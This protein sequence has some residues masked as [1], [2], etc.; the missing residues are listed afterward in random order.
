MARLSR[1]FGLAAL[2]ALQEWTLA[3]NAGLPD[4]L[5]AIQEAALP[6]IIDFEV[7]VRRT[8]PGGRCLADFQAKPKKGGKACFAPLAALF[9]DG[10]LQAIA[11]EIGNLIIAL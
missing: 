9:E 2:A 7:L 10:L 4:T 8:G 3:G 11:L 1:V 6:S 5:A